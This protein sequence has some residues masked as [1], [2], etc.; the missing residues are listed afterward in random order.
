MAP[1]LYMQYWVA[2]AR[3]MGQRCR[4]VLGGAPVIRM[5]GLNAANGPEA[6][7]SPNQQKGGPMLYSQ[8]WDRAAR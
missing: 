2:R 5:D 4:Q 6:S 8:A 1:E 7:H 3:S